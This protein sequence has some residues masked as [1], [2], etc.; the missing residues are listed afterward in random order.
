MQNMDDDDEEECEI[1]SRPGGQLAAAQYAAS[2]SD[3]NE[4]MN[5][6]GDDNELQQHINQLKR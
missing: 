2:K 3:N 4:V 1:E 6:E 5:D